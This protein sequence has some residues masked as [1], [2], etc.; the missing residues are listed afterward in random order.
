MNFLRFKTIYIFFIS[1]L[2]NSERINMVLP[3]LSRETSA[4]TQ[5]G[6][7][8]VL[9][10][11]VAKSASVTLTLLSTWKYLYEYIHRNGGL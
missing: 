1:T 4:R 6:H 11:R 3:R 2:E 10:K 8:Y 9:T 7:L 5:I